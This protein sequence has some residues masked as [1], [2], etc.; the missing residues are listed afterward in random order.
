MNFLAEMG[1]SPFE[2]R[3][4][5]RQVSGFCGNLSGQKG[6]LAILR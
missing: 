3:D 1:I 2:A 6:G 4:A 5:G